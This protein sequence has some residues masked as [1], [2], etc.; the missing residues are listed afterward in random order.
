[1]AHP[2]LGGELSRFFAGYDAVYLWFRP[3][4]V[5]A[6]APGMPRRSSISMLANG[7]FGGRK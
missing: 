2:E 5:T 6:R 7:M 3:L 1:M 4:A